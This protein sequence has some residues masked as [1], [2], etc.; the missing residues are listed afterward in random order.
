[1]NKNDF[2][3]NLWKQYLDCIESRNPEDYVVNIPQMDKFLEL[4]SFFKRIVG[5]DLG[6][7]I[8]P[9]RLDPRAEHGG[10]TAF[11]PFVA[12]SGDQIAE[13]GRV[14]QYASAF[15]IE[16]DDGQVIVSFTVPN[17]FRHK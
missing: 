9:L 11:F 14:L 17:I 2:I 13:F 1:M 5:Q 8:E 15:S 7:Y 16:G 10:F 3:S 12:L 6:G 4:L